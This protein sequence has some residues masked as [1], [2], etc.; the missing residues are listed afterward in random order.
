MFCDRLEA[1]VARGDTVGAED[2]GR[3]FMMCVTGL[4]MRAIDAQAKTA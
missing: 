4:R 2:A 3:S 1:G